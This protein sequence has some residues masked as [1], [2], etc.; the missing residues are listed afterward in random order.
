MNHTCCSLQT[1]KKEC[2]NRVEK[3]NQLCQ[4]CSDE[5]YGSPKVSDNGFCSRLQSRDI[6]GI[7]KA[8][9]EIIAEKKLQTEKSNR[10]IQTSFEAFGV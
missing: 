6:S 7:R 9:N 3:E 1:L 4:K 10:Y 8:I 2:D 5:Y